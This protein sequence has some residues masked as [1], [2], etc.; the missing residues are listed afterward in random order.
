MW[1]LIIT[2]WR[3]LI[4]QLAPADVA[5]PPALAAFL[6]GQ[7]VRAATYLYQST[8]PYLMQAPDWPAAIRTTERL[9][10]THVAAQDRTIAELENHYRGLESRYL[11]L[12]AEHD[13]MIASIEGATA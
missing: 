12:Q 10:R 6:A 3:W 7:S 11:R 4:E 9:I 8:D 5:M 13:R 1:Q 2:A